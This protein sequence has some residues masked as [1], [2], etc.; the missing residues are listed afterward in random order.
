[1]ILGV[2]GLGFILIRN[3]NQRKREFG[4][5]MATGFSVKKIRRM[6]FTDHSKILLAGIITGIVSALIATRPSIAGNA[7]IPWLTIGGMIFLILLTGFAALAISLRSVK[8][9]DL[10]TRIRKE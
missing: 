4:I 10:I 2:A 6:I 9:D 8:K 5:M 1:M 7:S 3:F